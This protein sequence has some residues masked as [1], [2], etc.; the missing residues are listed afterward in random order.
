[1]PFRGIFHRHRIGFGPTNLRRAVPHLHIDGPEGCLGEHRRQLFVEEDCVVG[2][3]RDLVLAIVEGH[4]RH[5]QGGYFLEGEASRRSAPLALSPGKAL[6]G[7]EINIFLLRAGAGDGDLAI[8]P[9]LG[10]AGLGA[11]ASVGL[12]TYPI[13]DVIALERLH[14][15]LHAFVVV[16]LAGIGTT[17]MS[18]HPVAVLHR[19]DGGG[20]HGVLHFGGNARCGAGGLGFNARILI[21]GVVNGEG[22]GVVSIAA[23]RIRGVV[24]QA[25]LDRCPPLRRDG[26]LLAA[27]SLEKRAFRRDIGRGN[28]RVEI[29]GLAEI[30]VTAAFAPVAH[31][32]AV[33]AR[34]NAHIIIGSA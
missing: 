15:Q 6:A 20:L 23:P 24:P 34:R 32:N 19:G 5:R 29:K 17:G 10:A 13:V 18:Q 21:R 25:V 31:R 22:A 12:I 1:M 28:G 16:S 26:H 2:I 27:G 14:L 33:L 4:I 30:P 3:R 8:L 7:S 9:Q 11:I